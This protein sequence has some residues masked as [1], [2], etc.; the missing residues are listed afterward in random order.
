MRQFTILTLLLL[1]LVNALPQQHK[2]D[3]AARE[4]IKTVTKERTVTVT[5]S[6]IIST[7]TLELVFLQNGYKTDCVRLRRSLRVLHSQL[8]Y[9]QQS[10]RVL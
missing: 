8:L 2:K 7:F 6:P 5:A 1:G 9:L 4:K 3:L 10:L